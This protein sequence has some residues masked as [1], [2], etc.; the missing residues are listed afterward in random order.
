MKNKS[1]RPFRILAVILALLLTAAQLDGCKPSGPALG[2]DATGQ[3]QLPDGWVALDISG[4]RIIRPDNASDAIVSLGTRLKSGLDGMSGTEIGISDDWL[5]D[6]NDGADKEILIGKTNRP[7]SAAAYGKLVKSSYIIEKKGDKIT[8]TGT[9]DYLTIRAVEYFLENLVAPAS[10]TGILQIKED[11]YYLSPS[12]NSVTLGGNGK[13]NYTIVRSDYSDEVIFKLATEIQ[14]T[15]IEAGGLGSVAIDTDWAKLGIARNQSA[16]EILIGDT[17][18]KETAEA[19]KILSSADYTISLVGNKIVVCGTNTTTTILAAK[20]FSELIRQSVTVDGSGGINLEL[21]YDAPMIFTCDDWPAIPAFE[22]GKFAGSYDCGDGAL[23][24][25]YEGTGEQDYRNYL[26]TLEKNGYLPYSENTIAGNLFADCINDT[27][28]VHISFIKNSGAIR[29]I[30][31]MKGELYPVNALQYTKIAE[32]SI[33]QLALDFKT[34][35]A[36]NGMGYIITLEDGSFIIYD[37]GFN[38]DA[39]QMYE[40]LR[41]MNKREGKPVI[42]AWV[43]T[44]VH[45]DHVQCFIRFAQNYSD[46]VELKYFLVNVPSAITMTSS[47]YS[48]SSEKYSSDVK[49]AAKAFKGVKQLKV[50]TGQ[51]LSFAGAE[52]EILYTHEALYPE[53]IEHHNNVSTVTRVNIAGQKIFMFGDAYKPVCDILVGM[54][55]NELKSDIVQVAHHGAVNGATAE[56]Y[57]LIGAVL[58]FVPYTQDGYK[59]SRTTEANQYILQSSRVIIADPKTETVFLPY[60]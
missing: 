42:S 31:E 29:I 1:V 21:I 48:D 38:A 30:S 20:K 33:T 11:C 23:E 26:E 2:S 53:V 43:L 10:E 41:T 3:T 59:A 5:P 54:Y 6:G 58:S 47:N 28:Q 57:K 34:N 52:L 9:N 18:Y 13:A 39:E 50:H 15:M 60:K 12:F 36:S 37:G 16:S 51:K 19:K 46:K 27:V 25:L 7:E 14:T 4:Y 56:A 17:N 8:I 35:N 32:P 44:H 45:T 22:A 55:G 49:N 40:L 24:L